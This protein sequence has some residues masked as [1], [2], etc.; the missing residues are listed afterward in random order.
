MR[1][2]QQQAE[3]FQ[4]RNFTSW[5]VFSKNPD[6]RGRKF[7]QNLEGESRLRFFQR[8]CYS[9]AITSVFESWDVGRP[10]SRQEPLVTTCSLA[11]AVPYQ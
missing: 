9:L 11:H 5:L 3:V 1:L 2:K 4:E 7:V 8:A 6:V 10:L